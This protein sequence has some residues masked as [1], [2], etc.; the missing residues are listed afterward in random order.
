VGCL[1]SPAWG[2]FQNGLA[3]Y[4]AGNYATALK[5]WRPLAEQGHAKAQHNIGVMYENGR[6]VP[7]DYAE[8]RRWYQ[9]AAEQGQ[10]FAQNNLG[11]MFERGPGM[12]QDYVQADMW[13]ILSAAQGNEVASRNH[14]TITKKMT[15]AQI[16]EAQKLAREWEPKKRRLP[17]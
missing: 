10:A 8:A 11:K 15:P 2:D 3:A 7:Q 4:R 5:E 16:A 6:G 1:V 17:Q 13:Y 14:T 12:P 9:K